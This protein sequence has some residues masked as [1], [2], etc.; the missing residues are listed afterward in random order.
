MKNE[1]DDIDL[2]DIANTLWSR[3]RIIIKNIL[4]FS[5][6]GVFIAIFSKAEYKSSILIVPQTNSKGLG[7]NIG[8]LA[9]MA[10]LNL[11]SVSDDSDISPLL[12]SKIL[13]SIPFQKEL[14]DTKLSISGFD[15]K[16]T[17]KDYYN[18]IHSPGVLGY[19][20]KYTIG[21][22][23]EIKKILKSNSTESKFKNNESALLTTSENEKELRE[24]LVNQI[25]IEVNEKENYVNIVA[26]MPQD[27]ASTEMVLKTKSLLQKYIINFKTQ[28]SLEKLKFIKDR[29]LEKEKEFKEIQEKLAKYK[30]KNRFVNSELQNAILLNLQSNYDLAYGVFSE[31]AKQLEAQEIKVKEDTPVFYILKPASVPFEKNKPKRIIIVFIAAFIGCVFSIGYVF[32]VK[33]F[34]KIKIK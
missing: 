34:E 12:Y 22:P 5:F 27:I 11:G 29:Y 18:D 13:Q 9:A 6:I 1:E 25:E 21:L 24:L 26:F 32:G 16:I 15:E 4:I 2:I 19:L 20:K 8:G 30:D 23:G 14:M 17:F 7:A 31:L 3:K 10:G 33:Y 28:K